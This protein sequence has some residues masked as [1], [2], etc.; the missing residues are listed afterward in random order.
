M[1]NRV[2]TQYNAWKPTGISKDKNKDLTT[3]N[4]KENIKLKTESEIKQEFSSFIV[5]WVNSQP[6]NVRTCLYQLV[7]L[8]GI[9]IV[10]NVN[11]T[12]DKIQQYVNE[13]SSKVNYNERLNCYLVIKGMHLILKLE[14]TNGTLKK[15]G[16]FSTDK[17]VCN[18]ANG[19]QKA[20]K[21]E[22]F[23]GENH[24]LLK[25]YLRGNDLKEYYIQSR[26]KYLD[27]ETTIIEHNNEAL[28]GVTYISKKGKP[29][30][31]L[32]TKIL[33]DDGTPIVCR[34]LSGAWLL[35]DKKEYHEMFTAE[36]IKT[37]KYLNDP[38]FTV[39][40]IR[41]KS[42]HYATEDTIGKSLAD[43]SRI[44][45]DAKL[46][47]VV[48]N[49][50]DDEPGHVISIKLENKL[51]G[52]I[53]KVFDPNT[54]NVHKRTVVKD[55]KTLEQLNLDDIHLDS[56][57]F[58]LDRLYELRNLDTSQVS[59]GKYPTH[60]A[61]CNN[62]IDVLELINQKM[63]A[64]GGAGPS[65]AIL[66]AILD[67]YKNNSPRVSRLVFA[68]AFSIALSHLPVPNRLELLNT[69]LAIKDLEKAK[70]EDISVAVLTSKL[71]NM[72]TLDKFVKI[73]TGTNNQIVIKDLLPKIYSNAFM[74]SSIGVRDILFHLD[75]TVKQEP[76]E[77]DV[78]FD[79]VGDTLEF[80]KKFYDK[81]IEDLKQNKAKKDI[82]SNIVILDK[83]AYLD[84]RKD[85]LKL[86][87]KFIGEIDTL[88]D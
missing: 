45:N 86:Q 37:N 43:I 54:T 50:P 75:K 1:E 42:I 14:L 83:T 8:I 66:R 15:A 25:D 68:Q 33:R 82:N 87:R 11:I 76:I 10:K 19:I 4:Q 55:L 57:K 56:S 20:N 52:I 13:L 84:I 34:H 41:P 60:D 38:M 36:L 2:I 88:T 85:L 48:T 12:P 39:Y 23:L 71:E 26:S 73:I 18:I 35:D 5:T 16:F 74:N 29:H 46:S 21:Q 22:A 69:F 9:D 78:A 6:E 62:V 32:N 7:Q 51:Y 64:H 61:S 81:Y 24:K 77:Q 28:D 3:L 70:F 17:V 72:D 58:K 59:A 65:A 67:D 53:V 80:V 63:C 49:S 27:R 40:S 79:I 30:I 31:N 44:N 47:I